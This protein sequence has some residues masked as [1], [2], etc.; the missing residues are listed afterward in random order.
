MEVRIFLAQFVDIFA[1]ILIF[2]IFVRVILSWIK[3]VNATSGV[4]RFLFEVTEPV[5]SIFRRVIPRLGM[6]DISPIVAF[7][8]IDLLRS[9][10]VNLLLPVAS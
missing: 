3:P 6:I 4:S 10:F 1:N 5:L 8:V 7:L 2:A 9:I